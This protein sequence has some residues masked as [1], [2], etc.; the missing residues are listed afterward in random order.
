VNSGQFFIAFGFIRGDRLEIASQD[1]VY[2]V[3][4]TVQPRWLQ[5]FGNEIKLRT[6]RCGRPAIGALIRPVM[7]LT[8]ADLLPG[9]IRPLLCPLEGLVPILIGTGSAQQIGVGASARAVRI[10]GGRIRYCSRMDD[11]LESVPAILDVNVRSD[12][13]GIY[14]V[15]RGRIGGRS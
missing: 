9:Y 14:G 7:H 3:R 15:W 2:S 12:D 11:L 1:R 8:G 6:A 5:P 10:A 4:A 13:C